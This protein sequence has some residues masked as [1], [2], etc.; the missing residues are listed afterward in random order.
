MHDE[1]GAIQVHHKRDAAGTTLVLV[2]G[3]P[4]I[5]DPDPV[6][7]GAGPCGTEI[8][9]VARTADAVRLLTRIGRGSRIC[10]KQGGMDENYFQ[11]FDR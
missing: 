4:A 11:I 5:P 2:G 1:K 6:P 3:T 10:A 9:A 7:P 8:Q